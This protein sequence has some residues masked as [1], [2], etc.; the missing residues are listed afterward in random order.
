MASAEPSGELITRPR[1]RLIVTADDF[2][3]SASINAAVR[4][5]H[6]DGILICASLMV[7]GD[8]LDEAVEIAKESPK[9]GVGLHLTLCCGRA[10]LPQ[11][12]IPDLV[13]E[14]GALP[15]SPAAA[16]I[17]YYFSKSL[18]AQLHAEISGQ[19]AKFAA[20]GLPL[21]HVNGHLHLHLHPTVLPIV[22]SEMKKHGCRSMRLTRPTELEWQLGRGRYFYRLSHW[23][24]FRALTR[25]AETVLQKAGIAD[26]PDVF[27]LLEDSRVTEDFLLRLLPILPKG[28][29]EVYA[30]PSLDEFRHEL[31]A[32]VS[33]R[34]KAA[35][36]EQG[37]QLIR[38]QD[39]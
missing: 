26:R 2:G 21:D 35:V 6:H 5:A 33:P 17:A 10:T 27:G 39:L 23:Y 36:A 12:E 32:L 28:S 29:S 8:G 13:G 25:R 37:I 19:F 3:R 11:S 34:V 31:D 4:Q 18:R 1:R 9:L 30:H 20:T 16:G 7:N 15:R 14:D 24:I 38:Y 22:I